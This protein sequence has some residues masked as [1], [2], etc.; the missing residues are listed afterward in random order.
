M[1]FVDDDDDDETILTLY[2]V[3]IT[4]LLGLSYNVASFIGS[5][6]SVD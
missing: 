4:L 5:A 6:I 1:K 2:G 3:H